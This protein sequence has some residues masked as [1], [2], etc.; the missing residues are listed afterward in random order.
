VESAS[1][2][3]NGIDGA[4]SMAGAKWIAWERMDDA[5]KIVPLV[6]G[7][8]KKEWGKRR[9]ILPLLRTS[10]T[11]T[12]E[13]KQATAFISGLGQFE[14]HLNGKK[15]GDHFLDPGWTNYTKQ[16]LYSLF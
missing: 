2:L 12:K 15:A 4:G 11:I 9:D 1:I 3:A 5:L 14:M 16:A 10:F 7:N 13:L 6:H 8:G